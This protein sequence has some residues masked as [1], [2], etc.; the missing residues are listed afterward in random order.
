ML[1]AINFLLRNFLH[2]V[3]LGHMMFGL[4]MVDGGW[5]VQCTCVV[6]CVTCCVINIKLV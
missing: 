2:G 3:K 4:V 5:M 6:K 1:A